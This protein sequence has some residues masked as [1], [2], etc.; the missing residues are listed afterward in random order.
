MGVADAFLNNAIERSEENLAAARLMA[1]YPAALQAAM[2][3]A[4]LSMCKLPKPSETELMYRREM[5]KQYANSSLLRGGE[6]LLMGK[7][8]NTAIE[9]TFALALAENPQVYEAAKFRVL[10]KLCVEQRIAA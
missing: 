6:L 3:R 2:H 8:G 7:I 5:L 9:E 4:E 1:Q 10:N